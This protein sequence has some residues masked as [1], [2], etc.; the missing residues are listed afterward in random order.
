MKRIILAAL[1]VC[2]VSPAWG[3]TAAGVYAAKL[4]PECSTFLSDYAMAELSQRGSKITYSNHFGDNIGWIAG[5]MTR[6][7][8][9]VRGKE[10]Y[11]RDLLEE[12]AWVASWC[13]DNPSLDLSD[14]MRA[15]TKA[16]TGRH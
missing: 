7:N 9:S 13:R 14:A 8:F 3:D 1:I 11:F 5:Y 15:I 16:R 2:V 12:V 10:N 4:S 6:V